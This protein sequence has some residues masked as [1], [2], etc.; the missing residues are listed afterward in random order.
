MRQIRVS[1]RIRMVS[2]SLHPAAAMRGMGQFKKPIAE[3]LA[4]SARWNQRADLPPR[5]FD[6]ALDLSPD[7][8]AE[9]LAKIPPRSVVAVDIETPRDNATNVLLVGISDGDGRAF[10]FD[11]RGNETALREFLARRDVLKVGHNI[12]YDRRGLRAIGCPLLAPFVDTMEA[13]ARLTPPFK[14]SKKRRWMALASC[15]LR[16]FDGWTYWK[17]ADLPSMRAWY[18]VN[19][20]PGHLVERAY[21]GFDVIW[22]RRLWLWQAEQLRRMG[23]WEVFETVTVPA[24]AVLH[25]LEWD[26]MRVDVDLLHALQISNDAEIVRLEAEVEATAQEMHAARRAAVG[27]GVAQIE[28]LIE[29]EKAATPSCPDHP[30]YNGLRK[31]TKK[32]ACSGCAARWTV[33]A[34]RRE[35]LARLTAARTKG[36]AVWKRI[37]DTFPHND[38]AWRALLFEPAP[39]GLG[40]DVVE[41]TKTGLPIVSKDVIETLWRAN[42]D[43]PILRKRVDL[44]HAYHRLTH[45]IGSSD[46]TVVA[47]ELDENNYVHFTYSQARA[48]NL[49]V[50][51]GRDDNEEDKIRESGGGNAQNLPDRDRRLFIAPPGMVLVDRDWSQIEARVMA[52]EA[53]EF[54]MLAAWAA[55]RDIHSING[56]ALAHALAGT[57]PKGDPRVEEYLGVTEKN[58][59]EVLFRFGGVEVSFR[60]GA[61]RATHGWDYGMYARKTG[62]MYG[63]P[64]RVAQAL[65]DAYFAQWPKLAVFQSAITERVLRTHELRNAFG[66][67][68]EFFGFEWDAYKRVWKLK[69]REEAFAYIPASS[70]AEMVK[71]GLPDMRTA[72]LECGGRLY[73]TTHDEYLAAVPDNSKVQDYITLTNG[74]MEKE[75][76]QFKTLPGFGRFRCPSD[77]AVGKN[78]GK[79]SDHAC[80]PKCPPTCD[81]RNVEGVRK[82]K[83]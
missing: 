43:I 64:Q 47:M 12:G 60:Y 77:V 55:G 2:V 17:E 7:E 24:S 11:P 1:S 19:G 38:N 66:G 79:W 50:A 16:A 49:R 15:V 45:I 23:L 5:V 20:V 68:M 56:A 32:T 10:V 35:R 30:K 75:W 67:R 76:P 46:G 52:W 34:P 39:V 83:R 27:D 37:G 71:S 78:W 51:S 59:D 62:K 33:E 61:K 81:K 58:A 8:I 57:L 73:T 63:V 54:A 4:R 80:T 22:T 72:A 69:D 6:L 29:Q 18:R 13:Q 44:Q 48:A 70:T 74:V 25:E 26:G 53:E 65:I 40:L 36:K 31:D 42:P 21:C 41:A 28:A 3:V 9:R 14:G 82:V